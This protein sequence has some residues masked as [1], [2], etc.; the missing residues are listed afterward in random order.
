MRMRVTMCAGEEEFPA[1]YP[2]VL[3]GIM[4]VDLAISYEGVQLG[5]IGQGAAARTNESSSIVHAVLWAC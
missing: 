2:D 4:I 1:S 3:H 5:R